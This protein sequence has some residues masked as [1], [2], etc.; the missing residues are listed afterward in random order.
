MKILD[1]I[2]S[3]F[4]SKEK[5]YAKVLAKKL[6][7][8]TVDDSKKILEEEKRLSKISDYNFH[9]D[10]EDRSATV[11]VM[12]GDKSITLIINPTVL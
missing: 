7:F 2:A 5:K 4:E 3:I 8:K 9:Y 1:K 12:F 10:N 11:K 6:F